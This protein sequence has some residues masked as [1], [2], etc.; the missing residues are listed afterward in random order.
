M[1][2]VSELFYEIQEMYID[3]VSIQN[4]SRILQCP[5][6]MVY[7]WI[8]SNNLDIQEEYDPYETINS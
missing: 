8:E 5:I 3:G 7:N 2:K 6:D 4:I 1:S